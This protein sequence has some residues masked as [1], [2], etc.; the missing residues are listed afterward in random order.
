MKHI[1][2]MSLLV[3]LVLSFML[4]GTAIAEDNLSLAIQDVILHEDGSMDLIIYAPLQDDLASSNL[5]LSID[6]QTVP[7]DSVKS[8][9]NADFSTTWLILSDRSTVGATKGLKALVSG[10][11]DMMAVGDNAGIIVTGNSYDQIALSE[12]QVSLKTLIESDLLKK[13]YQ[14][15]NL[16]A[17]ISSAI[18]YLNQFSQVRERACLVIISNGENTDETGMTAEELQQIVKE[19]N[20]TIY[21]FTFQEDSPRKTLI[22]QFEAL[23]RLSC[24]G[25]ATSVRSNANEATALESLAGM[26]A[27][28]RYFRVVSCNP[29]V[30]GIK[31]REI[32]L[33][34]N[35]GD[36]TVT[37]STYLTSDQEQEYSQIFAAL[38]TPVPTEAPTEVPTQAP[39]KAPTS[40]PSATPT[41]ALTASPTKAPGSSNVAASMPIVFGVVAAAIV[42]LLILLTSKKKKVGAK[43][44]TKSDESKDSAV[45]EGQKEGTGPEE[46]KKDSGVV[47]V[48]KSK[49]I[50]DTPEEANPPKA[51]LQVTLTSCDR[52]NSAVYQG[53][54]GKELIIGRD[55]K[56]AK[57]LSNCPDSSIS[58]IHLRLIYE[59]GLMK[60]RDISRNGTFINGKRM[61]DSVIL[62]SG[63]TIKMANSTFTITWKMY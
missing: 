32:S 44:E 10:V 11:I 2:N 39:T 40:T 27:N 25:I 6:G 16:N 58:G 28:E 59:D 37:A 51:L 60:A 46:G 33:S 43:D 34:L 48:K 18:Q 19:N 9:S 17:T 45:L 21:T 36:F 3:M 42:L 1:V 63:D 53:D 56:R 61:V 7:V 24:G 20:I 31:G 41:S 13:N 35:E 22:N 23:A 57:L 30:A 49:E 14:D 55:P 38:N 15:R 4:T 26:Q 62:H 54:M 52:G 29:A 8:F 12:D 47:E 5:T 50:I